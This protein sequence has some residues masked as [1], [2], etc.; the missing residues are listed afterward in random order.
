MVITKEDVQH[1]FRNKR[2]KRRKLLYCYYQDLFLSPLPAV[3]IAQKISLDLDLGL[4]VKIDTNLIYHTKQTI[5]REAA[6]SQKPPILSDS[7][8]PH[9]LTTKQAVN[10]NKTPIQ[11]PDT[12]TVIPT[13]NKYINYN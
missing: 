11:L 1:A 13:E 9:T 5:K 10:K 8:T 7:I 2:T 6:K 3:T 12:G 4:D